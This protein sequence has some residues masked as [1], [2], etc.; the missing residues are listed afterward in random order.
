MQILDV[1]DNN[2][3]KQITIN[4]G[5]KLLDLSTPKVMGILNVTPDS[6][7]TESRTQLS[8]EILKKT[9]QMILD[10]ADII[11]IGG[12]SSRPGAEL[13]SVQEEIERTALIQLI[14]SEFPETIL[15]IDT[16]RWEVAKEA[17]N[18]GA[19]IVNDITG[20]EGD[21]AMF[22]GIAENQIPY[23]L[24]HM[25]GDSS[26]MQ[27]LTDYDNLVKDIARYFSKKVEQLRNLGAKDIILDPG[28]G[29][30]KDLNQNYELMSKLE[31][32]KSFR[33]PILV[34]VSRKSMIYKLLEKTPHEALNGTTVLN[35]IGLMKGASILRVHDVKE[36]FECVR[37]VN[38]LT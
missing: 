20:G 11:D 26:T 31:L 13:I 29:F 2:F 33:E 15:S 19:H 3:N 9:E 17:Y 18:N 12:M 8:S 24:M 7:Y 30:A 34:G 37:L 23:I 25:R 16:F 1:Q 38:Q 21:T 28:F 14:S 32:F 6:F 27:Q 10:G 5:G 4:C 22:K 36:A 35:T